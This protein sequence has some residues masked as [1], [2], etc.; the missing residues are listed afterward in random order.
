MAQIAVNPQHQ[1]KTYHLTP[2]EPVKL[3]LTREVTEQAFEKYTELAEHRTYHDA[4]RLDFEQFFIEGMKVYAAYWRDDP[5]FDTTNTRAAAP[6]LP[7]PVMDAAFF[8]RICQFAI[9]THFGRRLSRPPVRPEFDVHEKMQRWTSAT[10]APIPRR[11]P[12][13]VGLRVDGAGGG[14]WELSLSNGRLISIDQGISDRC[15]ATFHL[16]SQT[17]AALASD[18]TTAREALKRGAVRIQ[19]NGFPL[20]TLAHVLEEAALGAP[21][22]PVQ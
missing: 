20:S 22:V 1:G 2:D 14:Q 16:N 21:G 6:H 7:C 10:D 11:K 18:A 4:E 17:F 15:T 13:Y 5:F 12:A 19:G 9:E 8:M 3:K